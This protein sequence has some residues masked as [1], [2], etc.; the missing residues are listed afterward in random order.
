M[1]WR[2][3]VRG[4]EIEPSLYAADFLRLGEQSEA[5]LTAGARVFHVDVGDGRFIPPV[6]IGPVVVQAVAPVVHRAGG[7]LD[8][9]LMVDAPDSHFEQIRQA[10]GDSVTFHLEVCPDP[11]TA[12]AA[13][14]A[15]GLGVGVAINPDTP[16][17]AAAAVAGDV[18]LVLCMSVHPGYSGQ[19]FIPESLERIRELRDLLGDGRLIQVD[20]GVTAGNVAEVRAAGADLI[21]AGSAIFY[22]GDVAGAYDG[23]VRAVA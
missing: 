2:D 20:G 4:V 10:G 9:H 18:D 23:L 15:C 1:S 7:R 3:W 16:I 17:A 11:A 22:H 13:A 21:V 6:T 14:R 8:C 5:L 19:A 12:V